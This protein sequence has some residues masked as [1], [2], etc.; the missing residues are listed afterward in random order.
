M[1]D[2]H[3]QNHPDASCMR[4]MDQALEKLQ[5]PIN[6]IDLFIIRDIIAIVHAGTGIKR[7]E[8]NG[9]HTQLL[10]IRQLFQNAAQ[11][12]DPVAVRV[13]ETL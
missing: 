4:L 6:R 12:A 7:R 13:S 3:V 5:I 10:Q 11:I 8:P 2:H 9:V 1:I